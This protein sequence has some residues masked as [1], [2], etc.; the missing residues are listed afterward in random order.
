MRSN[1]KLPFFTSF[2]WKRTFAKKNILTAKH[3]RYS[4]KNK[5][6]LI[7]PLI[8]NLKFF[9]YNGNSKFAV[10][11]KV[12]FFKQK[13]GCFIMTRKNFVFKS[14]KRKKQVR[15]SKKKKNTSK[16]KK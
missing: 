10:K 14:K 16:K 13:V 12:S 4:T 2:L 9:V 3:F 15:A 6:I 7:H 1:H 11:S 5:S 8:N